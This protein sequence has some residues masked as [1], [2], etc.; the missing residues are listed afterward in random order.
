MDGDKSEKQKRKTEAKNRSEKQKRKTEAKK[1]PMHHMRPKTLFMLLAA[2]ALALAA[3]DDNS[4]PASSNNQGAGTAAENT[5]QPQNRDANTVTL[6]SSDTWWDGIYLPTYVMKSILEDE[7]GYTV[8]VVNADSV[9]QFLDLVSSGVADI[10]MSGWFPTNDFTFERYNNLIRVGA[11]YGGAERDAYEGW[12]ATNELARQYDIERLADL[13]DPAIA[14]QLDYDNNGRGNIL[15]CVE[16][17]ACSQRHFEILEDY[18]LGSQYEVDVYGSEQAM[19]AELERRFAN[20][21]P[22]V[23]YYLQPVAF[24]EEGNID[25][26]AVWLEGTEPYLPLAFNRGVT[27]SDFVASHPDI[28]HIMQNFDM[29]GSDVSASMARVADEGNMDNVLEALADD[30]IAQNRAQVDSWLAPQ[31][32][33]NQN[34]DADTATADT[35]LARYASWPVDLPDDTLTIAYSQDKENLFVELATQYNLDREAGTPPIHPIPVRMADMLRDAGDGWYSAVSPDSS[36]WVSQMDREWAERNP[37]ASPLVG[38]IERYALTPVVIAM[39]EERAEAIGY[40]Q[41][42]VGWRDI[43]RIAQD[44]PGFRWSH[45]SASTA[46]GLLTVAAEFYAATDKESG[47]TAADVQSEAALEYVTEIEATVNRYGAESEDRVITRNLAAGGRQLDAFVTQEQKVI[48]FNQNSPSTRLVAAYPE[49]GTFWMDHPLILLDGPWVT[50]GQR[51]VFREFADFLEA[52]AAQQVVLQRGYRPADVSIALDTTNSQIREAFNVD[53]DEPQRLLQVPSPGVLQAIRA[54]WLQ[55]KRPASIVLVADISGSMQG[56][57]LAGA[58]SALLSFIDQIE[59]E[60]D[61][62]ALIAFSDNSALVQPLGPLNRDR[63]IQSITGLTAGGGTQL[64]DAIADALDHLDANADSGRARVIIAMTD[65]QSEGQLQTV[66]SKLA[67]SEQSTIIYTVGYGDDADMGVLQRIAQLGDGQ[68]YPSD[69]E[70][71]RRL[72]ALL[73]EFF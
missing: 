33:L 35:G 9:P 57:K 58:K 52:D 30:W 3:C 4:Q 28:V 72:Y 37:D 53:P 6:V 25:D 20:D 7:Y 56:A 32:A 40:P 68:V 38:T 10:F 70:T 50:D 65:G 42:R 15:G 26:F 47:L 59:S 69:P 67:D 44:D 51:R 45:P 61:H 54:A 11:A 62:V 39:L 2:L 19:L 66:E 46:T 12:M 24:P 13:L 64:Y 29:P 16:T 17:W 27:R 63:M 21:Q 1:G 71:I 22:A 31:A 5:R 41:E 48:F 14:A 55:T 60:R 49:E 36:I 34:A 18:G 23:F 8:N 43:M 73:S